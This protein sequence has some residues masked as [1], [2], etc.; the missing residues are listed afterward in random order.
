MRE[1]PGHIIDKLS[2]FSSNRTESS[3][4]HTVNRTVRQSTSLLLV[5]LV[6]GSEEEVMGVKSRG[7]QR[8]RRHLEQKVEFCVARFAHGGSDSPGNEHQIPLPKTAVDLSG[9]RIKVLKIS[10]PV[11]S[12]S[13]FSCGPIA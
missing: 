2:R 1:F 13:S 12:I 5:V 3:Q 8:S 7:P 11:T 10:A 9:S 4:I 6:D